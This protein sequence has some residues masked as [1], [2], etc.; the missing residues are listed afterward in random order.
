MSFILKSQF[1]GPFSP[2]W[3]NIHFYKRR[4]TTAPKL[5]E[6]Q[7]FSGL[8]EQKGDW[9]KVKPIHTYTYALS[10]GKECM[11]A[12][13][14]SHRNLIKKSQWNHLLFFFSMFTCE[15][16]LEWSNRWNRRIMRQIHGKQH[17]VTGCG[18][19]CRG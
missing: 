13:T 17:T 3:I 5:A 4:S 7:P 19:H 9:P 11:N 14:W 16:S 8:L 12:E 15:K 1:I 2:V 6:A 18:R 10:S